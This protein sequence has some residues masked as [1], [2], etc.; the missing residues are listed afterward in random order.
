M[1]IGSMRTSV[2]VENSETRA[3]KAEI[4]QKDDCSTISGCLEC[5]LFLLIPNTSCKKKMEGKQIPALY[6]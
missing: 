6:H 3:D 2:P 4:I 1:S 5:I